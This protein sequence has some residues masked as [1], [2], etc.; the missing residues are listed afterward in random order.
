MFNLKN[1]FKNLAHASSLALILQLFL[2]I[3]PALCQAYLQDLSPKA[4]KYIS[5]R[6]TGQGN[7]TPIIRADNPEQRKLICDPK[8]N[9]NTSTSYRE[10]VNLHQSALL[11]AESNQKLS[12]KNNQIIASIHQQLKVV[13][14]QLDQFLPGYVNY[15]TKR[16]ASYQE[17]DNLETNLSSIRKLSNFPIVGYNL[18]QE[19]NGDIILYGSGQN[20]SESTGPETQFNYNLTQS[21]YEGDLQFMPTEQEVNKIFNYYKRLSIFENANMYYSDKH[22]GDLLPKTFYNL[23]EI[24]DELIFNDKPEIVNKIKDST[25]PIMQFNYSTVNEIER[26]KSLFCSY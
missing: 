13:E 2:P 8:I 18:Y 12:I 21:K 1:C 7:E 10:L 24:R 22:G 23:D 11:E 15:E 17:K 3:L 25:L 20:D 4:Q 19:E 6:K 26:F 16:A 14:R 5:Y 9:G